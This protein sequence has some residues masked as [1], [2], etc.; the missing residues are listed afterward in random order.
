MYDEIH[1]FHQVGDLPHRGQIYSQNLKTR[2]CHERAGNTR[3][4]GL[5]EFHL[6]SLSPDH[7]QRV[8]GPLTK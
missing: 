7:D 1:E 2:E 5:A 6:V 3:E 4:E 8:C